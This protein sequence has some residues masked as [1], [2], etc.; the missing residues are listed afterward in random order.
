MV[1]KSE[2]QSWGADLSLGPDLFHSPGAIAV[3]VASYET[4]YVRV[5]TRAVCTVGSEAD[6]TGRKRVARD[7]HGGTFDLILR[8]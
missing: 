7:L 6:E 2:L 1:S 8:C 4:L 3:I 5:C